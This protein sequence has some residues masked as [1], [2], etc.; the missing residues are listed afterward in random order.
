MLQEKAYEPLGSTQTRR[1]DVRF[2]L[3]TNQHLPDLVAA[4]T[5]R[6]DLY[7][8]INVVNI[9]IPAL[10]E[11]PGD[12]PLLADHFLQKYNRE[13]KRNR[14]LGDESREAFQRYAW[15]GNVRELENAV[16]RAVVLS[17][18]P[19][20]TPADLPETL[21][22]DSPGLAGAGLRSG[23]GTIPALADG[24]TPT[25]LATGAPGPRTPDRPRRPPGQRL[26]PPTN[27]R[28]TRDQPH[29]PL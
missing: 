12:I 21:R 6:E 28:P 23:G 8:R 5:F 3:A 25:P 11:R 14:T 17:R 2:V 22:G 7:Y 24:W 20:I 4:G 15:P 29:H 10:R 16:E 9:T 18:E 19:Q 26:E 1:A 13:T 27:R